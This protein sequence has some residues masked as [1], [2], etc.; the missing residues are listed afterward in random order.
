LEVKEKKVIFRYQDQEI[1]EGFG[2]MERRIKA[3]QIH[4]H[5]ALYLQDL[6]YPMGTKHA[7]PIEAAEET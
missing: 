6:D 1:Q 2:Q 7:M 4:D 3:Q 5:L